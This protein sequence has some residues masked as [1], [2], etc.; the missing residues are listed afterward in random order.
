MRLLKNNGIANCMRQV[1]LLG[2]HFTHVLK[3]MWQRYADKNYSLDD[4]LNCDKF[5]LKN[6]KLPLIL[7]IGIFA[8]IVFSN[9][10]EIEF[11]EAEKIWI[12]EHPVIYHGYDPNWP[13]FEFYHEMDTTYTGIVGDY[14]KIVEDATGIVIRPKANMN[15]EK[16]INQ[17]ET[18]E[19]N[20]T[21]N[22]A[23]VEKRKE[24]LNFTKPYMSF[25]LFIVTRKDYDS[26]A[27]LEDFN[28]KEVS[29]PKDYYTTAMISKGFP[30]IKIIKTQ[31]VK[32]ALERVSSGQTDA[33]VG[34]RAVI[35]YYMCTGGFTNI[36]KAAPTKY[37]NIG[38]CFGIGKDLKE[39][40]SIANK[41]FKT[42]PQ[43]KHDAIRKEWILSD[44]LGMKL[45]EILRRELRE[46]RK[47]LL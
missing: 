10:Q 20:F 29:L 38:L 23:V 21:T 13:P 41:V 14:I 30:K 7:I 31:G 36:K 42:I 39:F 12:K 37:K 28:G 43:E 2:Y 24:F 19:V 5:R 8:A 34:N 11:T 27:G 17:L 9:A 15:W 40:E 35:N 33:F 6:K 18:G 32:E 26:I 44:K 16:T 3:S 22:I 47:W 45:K 1:F 46:L 4:G 25:P